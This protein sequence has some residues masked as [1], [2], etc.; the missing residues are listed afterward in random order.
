MIRTLFWRFVAA[1]QFFTRLPLPRDL[2]QVPIHQ[3]GAI[4]FFP[5]AG[6]V[7]GLL[8]GAVLLLARWLWPPAQALPKPSVP[9]AWARPATASG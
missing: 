6:I 8:C 7:V 3:S 5:W 9:A 4:G 1:L 2:P